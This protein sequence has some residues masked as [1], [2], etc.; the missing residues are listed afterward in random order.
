VERSGVGGKDVIRD[1]RRIIA[2]MQILL[3]QTNRLDQIPRQ[4]NLQLLKPSNAHPAAKGNGRAFADATCLGNL[5]D[6]HVNERLRLRDNQ[7]GDL[8]GFRRKI[9]LQF[10]NSG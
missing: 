5:G 7:L 2:P 4:K 1:G 8:L 9:R 3:N 10:T 6:R